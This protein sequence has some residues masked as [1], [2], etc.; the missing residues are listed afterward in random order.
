MTHLFNL[1]IYLLIR[2]LDY[3]QQGGDIYYMKQSLQTSLV[4]YQK[5]NTN[6]IS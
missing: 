4:I 2:Q 1:F 6:S 3:M 5:Q